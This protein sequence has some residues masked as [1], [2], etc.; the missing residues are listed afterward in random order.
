MCKITFEGPFDQ[1]IVKTSFRFNSNEISSFK[2]EGRSNGWSDFDSCENIPVF[3]KMISTCRAEDLNLKEI[4]TAIQS[5][6]M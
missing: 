3:L 4:F 1:T 5:V 6:I 2:E